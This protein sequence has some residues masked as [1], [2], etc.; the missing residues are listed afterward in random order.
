V[1]AAA[2]VAVGGYEKLGP[3]L[4][5]A[6]EVVRRYDLPAEREA[7]LGLLRHVDRMWAEG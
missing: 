2:D 3:L 1:F 7:F 6:A 4:A 5:N